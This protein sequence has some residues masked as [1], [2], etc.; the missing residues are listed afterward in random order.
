VHPQIEQAPGM[1]PRIR[2]VS[3][4]PSLLA[5]D[6]DFE[7]PARFTSDA[8]DAPMRAFAMSIREKIRRKFGDTFAQQFLDS[9][10]VTH[11]PLLS[12]AIRSISR[13]LC[14]SILQNTKRNGA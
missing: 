10:R 2:E 7:T 1:L 14:C 8:P 13:A 3:P 4:K 6:T 11:R 5:S 12:F 9:S